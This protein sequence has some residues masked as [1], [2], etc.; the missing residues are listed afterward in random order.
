M[1][2]AV[3]L[4]AHIDQPRGIVWRLGNQCGRVTVKAEP[5]AAAAF[6]RS[7]R[8]G[9]VVIGGVGPQ[10][11][12][13]FEKIDDRDDARPADEVTLRRFSRFCSIRSVVLPNGACRPED[14]A[15]HPQ[16][17]QGDFA[18]QIMLATVLQPANDHGVGGRPDRLANSRPLDHSP[19]GRPGTWHAMLAAETLGIAQLR[20][21]GIG[22]LG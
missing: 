13:V 3:R 2:R 7:Q 14:L 10:P 6:H 8:P 5:L 9:Q 20:R 11:D 1:E 21:Q 19:T 15:Y 18:G 12:A 17:L 16:V 4:D 22:L